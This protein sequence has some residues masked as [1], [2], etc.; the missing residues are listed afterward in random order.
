MKN[1]Q[2]VGSIR[3]HLAVIFLLYLGGKHRAPP[4]RLPLSLI[5]VL[6]TIG[7]HRPIQGQIFLP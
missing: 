1:K 2:H 4:P 6:V 7:A 3:I 5:W